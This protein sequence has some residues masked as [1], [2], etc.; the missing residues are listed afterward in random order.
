VYHRRRS[1][2]SSGRA[3]GRRDGLRVSRLSRRLCLLTRGGS[4][5]YGS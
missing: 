1:T 4:R 2:C 5:S 3:D